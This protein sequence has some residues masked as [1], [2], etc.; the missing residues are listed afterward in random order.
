MNIILISCVSKKG[1]SPCA[2]KNLYISDLFKKTK[3]Y[4]E[5]NGD[6]W[7]ILSAKYGLLEPD[8]PIAPYEETLNTKGKA[9]RI[10]W[11]QRVLTQLLPQVSSQD[12]I[13]FLAGLKYREFLADPLAEHGTSISIPMEGLKIGEQLRWLKNNE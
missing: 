11:A 5:K 13:T 4:A 6:K 7:F 3:A 12:T 10:E 1:T 9:A 2:A 8:A